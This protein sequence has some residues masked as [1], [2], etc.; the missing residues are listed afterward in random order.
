[1]LKL[2]Q[3]NKERELYDNMADLYSIIK[4]TEHL[5]KALM[6]DA[7][8]LEEHKAAC[9]KLITQFKTA[10]KLTQTSVPDL[11][12][13]M[14]EYRL[15]CHAALERL[16]GGPDDTPKVIA[17]TVQFFITAMDSLKLNM[18]AVD[19]LQPLLS[20]LFE[21]LTKVPVLGPDFEG[22]AKLNT[23]LT[24]MQGMKASDEL[25]EEQVRQLLFDLE[26]SYAA[27]HKALD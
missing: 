18:A 20:D 23:W 14:A 8:T 4:T 17:E 5:E 16:T 25:N 9:A 1:M 27:F 22:K 13:F 24:R 2:Y 15:D 12:K 3:N 21:C 11:S 10:R 26:S 7:I 6:R 19:Q